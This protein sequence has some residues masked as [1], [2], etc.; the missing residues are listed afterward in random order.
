MTDFLIYAKWSMLT[1][2][3]LNCAT[4]YTWEKKFML[5]LLISD[6]TISKEPS[7]LILLIL[8]VSGCSTKIKLV[9]VCTM[10][11]RKGI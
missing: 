7:M 1:L 4:I 9:H 3:K 11:M 5:T 6:G 10:C 8:N 2:L